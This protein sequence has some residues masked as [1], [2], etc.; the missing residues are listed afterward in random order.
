MAKPFKHTAHKIAR[1]EPIEEYYLDN[2]FRNANI[3]H[4]RDVDTIHFY[5][6]DDR[7]HFLINHLG[8]YSQWQG[9]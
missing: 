4:K 1:S 2:W 5:N 8:V 3:L 7:D 6:Q 9:D